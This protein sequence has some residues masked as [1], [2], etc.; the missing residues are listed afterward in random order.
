MSGVQ[1]CTAPPGALPL[2]HLAH[3][4]LALNFLGLFSSNASLSSDSFFHIYAI[5]LHTNR[6]FAMGPGETRGEPCRRS[7]VR[8]QVAA[9]LEGNAGVELARVRTLRGRRAEG[10]GVVAGC[11]LSEE[12]CFILT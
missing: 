1:N 8:T 7:Q 2:G 6:G 12:F 10:D 3:Q 9:S 11:G 5:R 4:T